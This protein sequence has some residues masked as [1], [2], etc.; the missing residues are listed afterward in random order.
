M[1]TEHMTEISQ[2]LSVQNYLRYTVKQYYSVYCD[3][4]CESLSGQDMKDHS[5][6]SL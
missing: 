2:L 5:S 6:G 1:M 4:D 3:D